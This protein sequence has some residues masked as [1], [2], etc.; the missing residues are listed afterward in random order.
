MYLYS[1]SRKKNVPVLQLQ[2][3]NHLLVPQH[4]NRKE[5]DHP[6]QRKTRNW[7]VLKA[8]II[9]NNYST[10]LLINYQL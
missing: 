9:H 7:L 5:G 1:Y 4:Y 3:Q 2:Q 6:A 8:S 10:E